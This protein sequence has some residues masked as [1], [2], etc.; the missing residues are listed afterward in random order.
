[1]K[2]QL[3][4]YF[5]GVATLSN[6]LYVLGIPSPGQ[7][8][9]AKLCG[10]TEDDGTNEEDM[11]RGAL[12]LGMTVDPHSEADPGEFVHWVDHSLYSCRPIALCVDQWEHWVLVY[13]QLGSASGIN[14]SF[15]VLDPTTWE[16]NGKH[17]GIRLYSELQLISRAKAG[18]RVRGDQ[19]PFYGIALGGK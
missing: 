1:M 8:K 17:A 5:C 4:D 13:A 19:H 2:L 7:Y 9:I 10:T 15:V 16:T 6:A 18:K 3:N 11:I 14:R 12:A